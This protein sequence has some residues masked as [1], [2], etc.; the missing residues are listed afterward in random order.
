MEKNKKNTPPASDEQQEAI[1][2][3]VVG[4]LVALLGAAVLYV[5]FFL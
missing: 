1:N 3:K 5:T 2:W 4:P